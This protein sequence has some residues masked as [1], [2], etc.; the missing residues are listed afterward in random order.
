MQKK[1]EGEWPQTN[2]SFIWQA[3][4]CG[5]REQLGGKGTSKLQ[6]IQV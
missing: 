4:S 1:G 5:E 6:R 2:I 3:K